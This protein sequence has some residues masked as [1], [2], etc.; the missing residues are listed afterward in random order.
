MRTDNAC[1][2]A[3]KR[4]EEAALITLPLDCTMLICSLPRAPL[5]TFQIVLPLTAYYPSFKHQTI[6]SSVRDCDT[7]ALR[8]AAM[9][10]RDHGVVNTRV[11]GGRT[12]KG[13]RKDFKRAALRATADK[14]ICGTDLIAGT[15]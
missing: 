12:H 13:S 8:V 10:K 6:V 1:T 11:L 3:S 15:G 14:G 5:A 7:S 2:A 4:R 9:K